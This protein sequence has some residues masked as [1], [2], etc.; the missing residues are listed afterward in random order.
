MFADLR[1]Y[2]G[3]IRTFQTAYLF[4]CTN[5]SSKSILIRSA[6]ITLWYNTSLNTN[7]FT[8]NVLIVYCSSIYYHDQSLNMV[9][10]HSGMR[11]RATMLLKKRRW[12]SINLFLKSLTRQMENV[13]I[14]LWHANNC[15]Q[16]KNLT[17]G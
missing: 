1:K 11:C 15:K 2:H 9:K 16:A 14:A 7:S 3:P 12:K 8:V 17:S 13:I 10:E 6:V 5:Q 4:M